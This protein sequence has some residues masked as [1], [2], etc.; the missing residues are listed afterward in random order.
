MGVKIFLIPFFFSPLNEFKTLSSFFTKS[1]R[2]F[3]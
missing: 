1:L 2:Q 3:G